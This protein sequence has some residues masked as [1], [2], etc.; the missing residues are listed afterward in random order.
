V[1][2]NPSFKRFQVLAEGVQGQIK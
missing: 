2:V 1:L